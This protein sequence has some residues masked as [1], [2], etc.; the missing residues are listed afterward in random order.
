M[1]AGTAS[2]HGQC[3]PMPMPMAMAGPYIGID[4]LP[5]SL[6]LWFITERTSKCETNSSYLLARPPTQ[7]DDAAGRRPVDVDRVVGTILGSRMVHGACAG[8]AAI[9]I[10]REV[11]VIVV[12]ID[13]SSAGTGS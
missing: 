1:A 3:L 5:R 7:D 13:S 10:T 12:F 6:V 8:P 2:M 11:V 4:L 9:G